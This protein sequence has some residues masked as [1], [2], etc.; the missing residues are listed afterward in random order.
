MP[1]VLSQ[2]PLA[3]QSS[4]TVQPARRVLERFHES[5][6]KVEADKRLAHFKMKINKMLFRELNPEEEQQFQQ[7]ATV[8]FQQLIMIKDFAVVVVGAGGTP[9]EWLEGLTAELIE[10]GIVKGPVV[11]SRAAIIDGNVKGPS[12]RTDLL[13]VFAPAAKPYIDNMDI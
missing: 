2:L 12:G 10:E 9:E 11:F 5:V 3:D 4:R 8:P 13:L 1:W 7:Y 6:R